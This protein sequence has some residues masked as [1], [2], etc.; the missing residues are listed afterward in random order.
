[1]SLK[2]GFNK[3]V[4]VKFTLSEFVH[5]YKRLAGLNLEGF[6][7][8]VNRTLDAIVSTS[9]FYSTQKS[10]TAARNVSRGQ[11]PKNNNSFVMVPTSLHRHYTSSSQN[12]NNNS[13]T[14]VRLSMKHAQE[15]QHFNQYHGGQ[16][17]TKGF[18]CYQTL[19]DVNNPKYASATGKAYILIIG[20]KIFRIC[21]NSSPGFNFKNEV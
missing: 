2:K 1:M 17:S 16:P 21:P 11:K 7:E 19:M 13:K 5:C 9:M 15:Y 4:E 6:A 12:N 8:F 18:T 3:A 20:K 14:Y 10:M